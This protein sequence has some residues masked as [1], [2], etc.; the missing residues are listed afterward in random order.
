MDYTIQPPG[1]IEGA[2][3][4]PSDKSIAHRA[5]LF[6][7]L[8]D[9]CSRIANYS[10]AADPQSTLKCL[11]ALGVPMSTGQDGKGGQTVSIE[12]HGRQGLMSL[13]AQHELELD[14][15]NSGTTMRLLT[16]IVA[17]AGIA[18]RL[19][20][21]ASLQQ[22]PMKRIIDP[23]RLMGA[24]I[25]G[26][27][28]KETA[29][30]QVKAIDSRLKGIDY[31]LPIPSAQLKSCVLLAG[32]FADSPTRVFETIPSR[33]HTERLLRLP[34]SGQE[35]YRVI[36]ASNTHPIPAQNYTI[37]NDFSAAAFWLVAAAIHD[38]AE[39]TLPNVGLNPT[40]TALLDVLKEMGADLDIYPH[41]EET[42]EPAG[43]I[44]ARSSTLKATEVP[45]GK[46]PNCIDEIPVMAV[47]MSFAE[48]TSVIY[49]VEELRYKESDRL[50]AISHLLE[51]AG[52]SHSIEEDALT[53]NGAPQYKPKGARFK[54]FNDHRIAMA[55]AIMALRCGSDSLIEQG[56][57]ASIS[58]PSFWDDMTAVSH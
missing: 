9:A 26:H 23:L 39:I 13:P 49:G 28:D 41:Q 42:R 50:M 32:L 55:A 52:I 37:P 44:T 15:G 43:A 5:A 29:P 2:I 38:N 53:I 45:S 54:S 12:G 33:D 25:G 11:K 51:R 47:A 40:R 1:R 10:P 4:L 46:V 7:S 24:D 20:G 31:R 35:G 57:A 48:G 17:G 27:T 3:E 30:L 21:D 16:G 22:R 36:E 56:D 6:A 14:C 8:A 19:T 18:A 34:Q 58:Y